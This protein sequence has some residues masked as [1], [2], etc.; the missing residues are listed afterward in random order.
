MGDT[1]GISWTDHTWNPWVGCRHVSSGCANCYMF[2]DM[3]RYGQDASAVRRT[4][5]WRD[6]IKW[7]RQAKQDGVRRRVF[8]CSWSDFFIEEADEWRD[9][10]WDVIERCPNLDFQIL[11]KRP[12]RILD[13]LPLPPRL[14]RGVEPPSIPPNAW[15]GV[16]V[17]NRRQGVPR[18]DIL[19]EVPAIR[20]LSAEPLLE[21]LGKLDLRGIHW[22]II[23]GESGP[24]A[25]PFDPQWGMRVAA[26]CTTRRI[27]VY[28]KQY[29]AVVAR[30]R[31]WAD[32]KGASPKEWPRSTRHMQHFPETSHA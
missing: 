30:K 31:G 18:I 2:S 3:K 20:F 21:D 19:R 26:Q 23:G 5:T 24:R 8:T 22:V 4:K 10:A 27:P 11:T 9:A 17:E 7:N 15:I 13:H 14:L 28:W 25:R 12:E 16:S 32:S 1:T 6:P 29:G